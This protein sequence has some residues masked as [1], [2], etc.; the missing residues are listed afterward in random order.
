MDTTLPV[1]TFIFLALFSL[2]MNVIVTETMLSETE[3]DAGFGGRFFVF[4]KIS[5]N[6]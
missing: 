5:N 2:V 4:G 6:L 1:I 3:R